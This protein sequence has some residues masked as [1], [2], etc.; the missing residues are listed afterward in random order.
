[1]LKKIRKILIYVVMLFIVTGCAQKFDNLKGKWIATPSNQNVY[2]RDQDGNKM[3]GKK[4]YILECD[5]KGKYR[6]ILENNHTKKGTYTITSDNKVTFMDEKGMLLAYCD[7]K[8]S[9]LNCMEKSTYAFKYIKKN[10]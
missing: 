2:L 6:L 7:L 3:G 8:D 4:D 5:G 9:T 1:M 10:K